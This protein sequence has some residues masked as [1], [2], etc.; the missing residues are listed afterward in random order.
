MS[1]QSFKTVKSSYTIGGSSGQ[2][3]VGGLG[4]GISQYG[5]GGGSFGFSSGSRTQYGSNVS[6]G[7]GGGRVRYAQSAIMSSSARPMSY[8]ST[9]RYGGGSAGGFGA[10]GIIMGGGGYCGVGATISNVQVN[11]S[12]LTPVKLDIDTTIHGVRTQEKEQIKNLNN[13]FASFI[14]QVSDASRFLKMQLSNCTWPTKSTSEVYFYH[15]TQK[16]F[17]GVHRTIW[18]SLIY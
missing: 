13:R 18:N 11:Q 15:F 8:A 12:L 3:S 2:A 5:S 4:G 14:D 9:A 17:P 16:M 6:H 1:R 7:G 10:G